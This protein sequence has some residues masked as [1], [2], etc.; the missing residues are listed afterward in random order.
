MVRTKAV[1]DGTWGSVDTWDGLKEGMVGMADWTNMPADVAAVATD[2]RKKIV[3]GAFNAFQGPIY[4]QDGS[5]AV[6]AGE[7]LDADH[8]LLFRRVF[9]S[10]E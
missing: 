5:Q 6:A 9:R 7:V 8:F 1:L 2:T 3:S 4:R 10:G